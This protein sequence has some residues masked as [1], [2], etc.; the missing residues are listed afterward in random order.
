VYHPYVPFSTA[1]H[2]LTL[3][4]AGLENA[5]RF[6]HQGIT[7]PPRVKFPV[8]SC[9]ASS[10]SHTAPAAPC[11]TSRS[12][13]PPHLLHR[14]RRGTRSCP[15]SLTGRTSCR[16]DHGRNDPSQ[17][18]KIPSSKTGEGGT[19][20]TSS[21]TAM[22]SNFIRVKARSRRTNPGIRQ[23][24]SAYDPTNFSGERPSRLYCCCA[25]LSRIARTH[26]S[27]TA[28]SRLHWPQCPR[29]FYLNQRFGHSS[30]PS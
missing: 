5:Q 3:I 29:C 19:S 6:P 20:P 28:C 10:A 11:E 23:R 17:R 13:R 4:G 7:F 2:F 24:R 15:S 18:A 9:G 26:V 30:K 27:K 8:K 14:H 25:G 12:A 16:N 1:R 21:R 22:K